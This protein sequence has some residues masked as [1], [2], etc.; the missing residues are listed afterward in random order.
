[1]GKLI[2]S[3]EAW[4]NY[5]DWQSRDSKTVKRINQLIQSIQ[6]DG[7]NSGIGKPEKLKYREGW[8]R[9]IDEKNRL[10]YTV[11]GDDVMILDCL[12]HY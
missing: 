7:V 1:M 8:S 6:R 11:S 5:Q 3:D 9:R 12:G 2:F 10:I 4:K